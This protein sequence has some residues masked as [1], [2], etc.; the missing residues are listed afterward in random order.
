MMEVTFASPDM[1]KAFAGE[2]HGAQYTEGARKVRAKVGK[3]LDT[4]VKKAGRYTV[5]DWNVQTQSLEEFFLHF[6]GGE[7]EKV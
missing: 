5:T 6:Y 7:E 2:I 4:F 3:E 1:A